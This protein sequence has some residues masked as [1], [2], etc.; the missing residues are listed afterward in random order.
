MND[1]QIIEYLRSR[2]RA[3]PPP[4]LIQAVMA[5]V[6][7]TPP[8][9][10]WFAPFIPAIAVAAVAGALL[11]LALLIGQRPVGPAPIGSEQPTPS[12]TEAPSAS[13]T[14][15]PSASQLSL[16]EPGAVVDIPAVDATGQW[17]TI[18]IERGEELGGYA[19]AAVDPATFVVELLVSYTPERMPDPAEF[20]LSDWHLRPTDPDP[21]FSFL[22]EARL[23]ER[24]NGVGF[25]PTMPLGEYPGA[26][27]IF[28]TPT[29]GRIAFAIP[30]N[31]AALSVEL[32]YQLGEQEMVVALR[33]PG[34]PPDPVPVATPQPTSEAAIAEAAATAATL[35]TAIDECT[36][37]VD[38]YTLTFPDAWYTNTA[39]G[40][41]PACSWFTPEFYEV[42][43]PGV[44][45]DEIWIEIGVIDGMV[46]YTGL[47]EIYLNEQL[48]VDGRPAARVEYNANARADP[49]HRGYQYVILLGE[50]GPTLVAAT[51]TDRADNYLLAKAVLDR[52]MASFAF[53]D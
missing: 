21:E 44:A 17:G 32:V 6:E 30:R 9:R 19:D 15:S 45:P 7:S 46:G 39:T 14:A 37:P 41:V 27:D 3:E 13:P 28:T 42:A 18:H 53:E 43:S 29:E 52:I 22:A 31:G 10:S 16:V 47:T 20:G 38:G 35:F 5:A 4:Q 40:D 11:M 26:V 50:N 2:A 33:E 48:E 51:S 34:P 8:P 36:N 49:D 24:A 12:A 1:E 23:F 25:R